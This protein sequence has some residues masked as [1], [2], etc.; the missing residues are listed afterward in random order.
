MSIV[1]KSHF[2]L[3][4]ALFLYL[5]ATSRGQITVGHTIAGKVQS[6]GGQPMANLLVEIQTGNGQPINQT[7]TT[8]EGDYAFRGLTGGS[9]ILVVNEPYHQPF[10]ERIEMAR[11]AEDRPGETIRVDIT[12]IPKPNHTEIQ[13]GTVF[14]QDIPPAALEAYKNGSKLMSERKY[15]AGLIALQEAVKLFPRYFDAHLAIGVEMLRLHRHNEA[16][17][18]LEQARA[19]NPKDSR[20]YHTFGLVLYEQ[21]NYAM[22]VQVFDASLQLNPTNADSFLLKG[23]SLLELGKFDEAEKALRQAYQLGGSKAAMAHLHLARIYEKRGE[24]NRAADELEAYLKDKPNAD[25]A[26]GIR[27]AIDKLR[28]K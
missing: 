10:S 5:P 17:A 24:R 25:N 7:T 19:I 13:N 2:L 14:K 1:R 18:E 6:K 12:L 20:L 21:K 16:I 22:A 4:V 8:N 15:E 27:Q 23:A 28:A 11:T 26:A 3:F 9:F